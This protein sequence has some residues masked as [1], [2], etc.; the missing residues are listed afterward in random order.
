MNLGESLRNELDRTRMQTP[1]K[2][3][4]QRASVLSRELI[5]M[6][7]REFRFWEV[8]SP[9]RSQVLD[10]VLS[11]AYPLNWRTLWRT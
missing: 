7:A 6:Q 2:H 9:M 10:D 4:A 11:R 5:T 1:Y 8:R 3:L